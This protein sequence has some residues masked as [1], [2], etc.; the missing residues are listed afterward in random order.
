MEY[1]DDVF[2]KI[3]ESYKSGELPTEQQKSR[4]LDQILSR[5]R[6]YDGDIQS[7]FLH[8]VSMYPWRFAFGAAVIQTALATLILGKEYT[9]VLIGI[10]GG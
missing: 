1:N 3:F 9:N 7:R 2:H 10:I 8:F 6:S 4:M 5:A